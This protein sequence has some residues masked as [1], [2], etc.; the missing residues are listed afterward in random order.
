MFFSYRDENVEMVYSCY[1]KSDSGS[2]VG[3]KI[4][5][6][7]KRGGEKLIIKWID[8]IENDSKIAILNQKC[9]MIYNYTMHTHILYWW[10]TT[11]YNW[12]MVMKQMIDYMRFDH[13][14]G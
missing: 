8:K 4:V 12:G 13:G 10:M 11:I 3:M 5:A 6:E 2:G 9:S 14:K 7:G 1:D